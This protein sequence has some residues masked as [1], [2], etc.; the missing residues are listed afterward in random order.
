MIIL[1]DQSAPMPDRNTQ[2]NAKLFGILRGNDVQLVK[3]TQFG[4]I[5]MVDINK[6]NQLISNLLKIMIDESI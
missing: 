3:D 2:A 4:N 5:G 6:F 1:I